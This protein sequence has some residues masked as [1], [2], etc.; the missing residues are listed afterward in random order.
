MPNLALSILRMCIT[1]KLRQL[2]STLRRRN[3][4]ITF[5]IRGGSHCCPTLPSFAVD[6]GPVASKDVMSGA[7]RCNQR[8]WLTGVWKLAQAQPNLYL[9]V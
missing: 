3:L 4:P 5:A 8:S 1:C 2:E 7:S 9:P 6:R